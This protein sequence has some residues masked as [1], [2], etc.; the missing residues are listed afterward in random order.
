MKYQMPIPIVAAKRSP[1]GRFGG[2]L[3]SLSAA[4]IGHQ[5]VSGALT[6][7]MIDATQLTIAG[8]V[9]QAGCGM[10]PSRQLALASGISQDS[11]AY[12]I[13]MVCGSGL[14]AVTAIADTIALGEIGCGLA[15]GMESMT[16]APFYST[17]QRWGSKFGDVTL[18]DA[19]QMDG[20]T[21]PTLAIPMGETAERIAA[22]LDISRDEQ[23][24]FAVE[25]QQRTC[26]G[27]ESEI[28][29][30]V[31]RDGTIS[32]DEHPRP[33]TTREKLGA[34]K[35]AFRPDGTVTAG[36]SSGINDGA[37]AI[38]LCNKASAATHG[39]KPLARVVGHS[40]IGCDPG[41]MGLGPVPA[42]RRLLA[43]IGWSIDD[44]DCFEINEAFAAQAIACIRLLDLPA[45]RVN[46]RGGAIALG[47]PIGCS[48]TRILVTL[49]HNLIRNDQ[50]CGVAAL[51]VGGG[52]GIAIAV[53][54]G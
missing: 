22:H 7:E 32:T 12:T 9:L 50:K 13:N 53:E 10:N 1:I 43:E 17:Q 49:L 31:S 40:V 30:V 52:M 20:L 28:I 8:Q 11:P 54:R 42:I 41:M 47:H 46:P 23:D 34:L 29:P 27:F 19:V 25:S 33:G 39:W 16:Q 36:N 48:G 3:K 21:D 24:A 2:G 38:F 35:P 14:K 26:A 45:D 15:V 18:R 44:V 6:A 5:V 4:A 37:A 51:C